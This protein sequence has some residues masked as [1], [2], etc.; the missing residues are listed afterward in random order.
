M[1]STTDVIGLVDHDVIATLVAPFS[2]F[3]VYIAS[4]DA[5]PGSA[6]DLRFVAGSI[7]GGTVD[8]ILEELG[9]RERLRRDGAW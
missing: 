1:I 5:E 2:V 9:R 3:T 6:A 4:D 7:G 8:G